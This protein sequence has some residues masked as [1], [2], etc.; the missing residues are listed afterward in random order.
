MKDAPENS[1]YSPVV[2]IFL[3]YV[4]FSIAR[5]KVV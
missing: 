5:E 3:P 4:H 1:D 2:T